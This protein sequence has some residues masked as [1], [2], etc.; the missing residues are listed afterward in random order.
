M[1]LKG[2]D[3]I[4]TNIESKKFEDLFLYGRRSRKSS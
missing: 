3:K 1:S 2:G 4:G